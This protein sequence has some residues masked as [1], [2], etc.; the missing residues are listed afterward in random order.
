[1]SFCMTVLYPV[2][3]KQLNAEGIQLNFYL[4]IFLTHSIRKNNVIAC[5]SPLVQWARCTRVEW[6]I[7]ET[8]RRHRRYRIQVI[9][10]VRR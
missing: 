7:F 2:F 8:F 9:H 1:M 6:K 10:S 3:S 5:R 4:G